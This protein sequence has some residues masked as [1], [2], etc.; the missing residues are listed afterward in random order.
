M[1]FM[2]KHNKKLGKREARANRKKRAEKLSKTCRGPVQTLEDTQKAKEKQVARLQHELHI[3][4]LAQSPRQEATFSPDEPP[5]FKR[6]KSD[7]VEPASI[8]APAQVDSLTLFKHVERIKGKVNWSRVAGSFK[9]NSGQA[10]KRI[11]DNHVKVSLSLLPE[12]HDPAPHISALD[13]PRKRKL[14][15]SPKINCVWFPSLLTLLTG[16]CTSEGGWLRGAALERIIDELRL[17][18]FIEEEGAPNA[19]L[20]TI[21]RL[22]QQTYDKIMLWAAPV[23]KSTDKHLTEGRLDAQQEPRNHIAFASVVQAEMHDRPIAKELIC[24]A[25]MFTFWHDPGSGKT[26]WVRM[27]Q[28]AADQLRDQKLGPGYSGKRKDKPVM[29]KG[30]IPVYGCIDASGDIVC[31]VEIFADPGV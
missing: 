19:N 23:G 25:D 24:S 6:Q 15:V 27:T 16:T 10:A 20:E 21:G 9:L 11:Y 30:A 28:A 8:K 14:L 22:C 7:I 1:P 31:L 26:K 3:G 13:I 4:L 18:Q 29:G 2:V 12:N 17:E 5:P